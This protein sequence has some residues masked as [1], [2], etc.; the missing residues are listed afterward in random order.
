MENRYKSGFDSYLDGS[1]LMVWHIDGATISSLIPTNTINSNECTSTVPGAC[2]GAANHYGVA[3]LQAD[4]ALH[5]ENGLNRGDA[6]DPFNA[7]QFFSDA[8]APASTLWDG[9]ASWADVSY[10]S[11]SGPIMTATFSFVPG[12]VNGICGNANGRIFA[13]APAA[14]LCS[15]GSASAVAGS[16][17]WSWS[18]SGAGGGATA[19]CGTGTAIAAADFGS[20]ALP[21]GWI[22]VDNV[23]AGDVW[24]FDDPSG[25]ENTTGGSGCFAMADSD[26][27][28]LNRQ[29][30]TELRSPAYDLSHY[31]AVRLDFRTYYLNNSND[32]AAVDVSGDGGATWITVWEKKATDV[33]PFPNN[34]YVGNESVDI[35]SIAAGKA[36]VK[37]RFHY[38]DAYFD[39]YWQVDDVVL[40]GASAPRARI[41]SVGYSSLATAYAA[42]VTGDVIKALAGT[43]PDNGLN[44]NDALAGGKEVFILGGYDIDYSSRNGLP[45]TYLKGPLTISSGR[46]TIDGLTIRP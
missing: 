41:G 11:A 33:P 39:W 17:P 14:G 20:C 43:L 38:Y 29:M 15:S 36:D 7:P 37:F 4:S 26:W 13:S 40:S 44:I 22:I 34:F 8:S 9:T 46:A 25:W 28:G 2:S 32:I 10:L 18:C 12:L 5:L 21:A 45:V 31:A 30:D 19:Y 16:G 3:P 23:G 24:R 27:A 6:A 1:G 35:S 42:A